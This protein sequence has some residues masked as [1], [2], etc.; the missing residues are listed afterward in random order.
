M[1]YFWAGG[2]QLQNNQANGQSQFTGFSVCHPIYNDLTMHLSLWHAVCSAILST[3]ATA[4]FM[5][6]P[7]RKGSMITNPYSNLLTTYPHL[8][9]KLGTYPS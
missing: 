2:E 8:C 6:L 9:H 3:E 1:T 4:T 7:S 5:F